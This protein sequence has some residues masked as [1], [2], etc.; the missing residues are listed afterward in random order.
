MTKRTA[1]AIAATLLASAASA[2][3]QKALNQ[4][5]E[6]RQAV[7]DAVKGLSPAQWTFKPTPDRWSIAE[8]V[9]HITVTQ[10]YVKTVFAQFPQAPAPAADFD[11]AKVDAIIQSKMPD[12]STKYKAPEP[13]QPTGRWSPEETLQ[14]FV[15]GNQQIAE[16]FRTLPDPRNHVVPHPA[17]G[18][19]NGYE[20][21]LTVAGHNQRHTAQILEVKADPHFP[22]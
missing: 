10:D 6:S 2:Q 18:P 3:E 12:R 19:L 20:W 17:L 13:I 8:I 4:L 14:H 1:L 11:A 7:L 21:V 15:A 5:A 9:E 16:V 22:R